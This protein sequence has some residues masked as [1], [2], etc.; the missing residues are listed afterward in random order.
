MDWCHLT[1]ILRGKK[2]EKKEQL[3]YSDVND[4]ALTLGID[5]NA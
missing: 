1:K 5:V 2:G 3:G 4:G